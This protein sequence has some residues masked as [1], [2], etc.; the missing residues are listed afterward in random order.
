MCIIYRYIRQCG[1]LLKCTVM[2]TVLRPGSSSADRIKYIYRN[3][4][5]CWRRTDQRSQRDRVHLHN[6]YQ[7]GSVPRAYR[8]KDKLFHFPLS[9][10]SPFHIDFL[11]LYRIETCSQTVKPRGL[12]YTRSRRGVFTHTR[13]SEGGRSP[14]MRP[15]AVLN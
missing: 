6:L 10:N 15:P 2:T 7:R 12:H 8:S 3:S 4:G 11:L 13:S 5:V 1:W 9:C 14:S